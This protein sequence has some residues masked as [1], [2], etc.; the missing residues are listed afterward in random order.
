MVDVLHLV[1][2]YGLLEPNVHKTRWPL[3]FACGSQLRVTQTWDSSA[4]CKTRL[5]ARHPKALIEWPSKQNSVPA[6]HF[7][8]SEQAADSH[9]KG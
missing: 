4:M 6:S 5:F 7:V 3:S 2:S 8:P 9:S 1:K